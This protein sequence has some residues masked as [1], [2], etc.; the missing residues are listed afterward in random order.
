[1]PPPQSTST[2]S[3]FAASW[4]FPWR[5][6]IASTTFLPGTLASAVLAGE[7]RTLLSWNRLQSAWFG[8]FWGWAGPLVRMSAEENVVPLLEGRVTG[9][10]IVE[11]SAAHARGV[12]GTVLEIGP[13]SGNWVSIFSDRYLSSTGSS[14]STSASLSNPNPDTAAAPGSRGKVTRVFGVEPNAGVHAELRAKIVAAGLEDVYEIVPVG[15]QD[16]ASSGRVPLESV[17]CIVTVMCLCSIPDPQLNIKELYGYLKPG[18]RWFVY[19]H[20]K[21]SH[22][23]SWVV[24]AYQ[25]FMNLIWP[26]F[27]GG[28]QLRRDTGKWIKEAGPWSNVDLTAPHGQPWFHVLPHVIGILTK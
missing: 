2:I 22:S 6:M 24:D 12:G 3:D 4:F 25:G 23:Q 11:R 15:I 26:P 27:I 13:G 21:C 14:T 18:G 9:G 7:W 19:E 16:L 28:C 10:R 17:D 1:M 5:F 20:V 8:R